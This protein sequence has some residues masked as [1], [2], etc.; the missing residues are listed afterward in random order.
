MKSEIRNFKTETKA[1]N[2][3]TTVGGYA[4]VFN[5]K[6]NMG[7]FIES[8]EPGAFDEA[9]MSDVRLLY[10]HD[11]VPLARSSAGT[12][13]L[14]VDDYGLR[15]IAALS[16]TELAR[17]IADSARRGDISQSSFAFTIESQRW[18]ETG[19]K[20]HR[21]IERVGTVTDVSPVSFPAYSGTKFHVVEA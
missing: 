12:L 21:I 15:Y 19:G 9:D 2:T 10:N 16:D 13:A 18:E 4:A 14:M 8:I 11:G 7:S 5:Q 3:G 1:S 20:L 6:T 17:Q